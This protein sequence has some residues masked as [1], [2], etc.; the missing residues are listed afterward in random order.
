[1][2]EGDVQAST[3]YYEELYSSE[4]VPAP[5][6]LIGGK[7]GLGAVSVVSIGSAGEYSRGEILMTGT[8]GFM[9]ATVEGLSTAKEVCV[10]C[11]DVTLGDGETA[12]RPA[13]FMGQFNMRRVKIGGQLLKEYTAQEQVAI[14]ALLRQH[15]IFVV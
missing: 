13:Y 14:I 1:M 10:L 4:E 2:S 11:D 9:K 7:F 5:D 3:E 15:K 8:G 12:D 6:D